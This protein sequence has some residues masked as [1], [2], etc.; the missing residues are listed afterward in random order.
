MYI[1]EVTSRYRNDFQFNAYC[2]HCRK[3]SWHGD[4]YANANYQ[5]EVF[6]ARCCEHCGLNEHGETAEEIEAARVAKNSA[7]A[8]A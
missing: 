1:V 4:G 6:P 2:R 5:N 8:T 3:K 7:P